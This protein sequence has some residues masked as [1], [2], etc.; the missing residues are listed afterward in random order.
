MHSGTYRHHS[1]HM[2]PHLNAEPRWRQVRLGLG[3]VLL[4]YLAVGAAAVAGSALLWLAFH[5]NQ[6][7]QGLA[8][9]EDGK[10]L[11]TVGGVAALGLGVL[12]GSVLVLAGQWLCLTNAPSR[13]SARELMLIALLCSILGLGITG[14][15]PFV[16]GS[17]TYAAL[18][19]G[20][21]G[22]DHLGLL[23]GGLL[24]HL[25]GLALGL[26]SC[27]TFCLFLRAI[28]SYFGSPE[29]ARHI[30]IHL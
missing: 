23:S 12:I 25:L 8:D 3:L 24:V 4:G 22:F 10:N 21:E 9:G 2:I 14:L 1:S 20:V 18:L 13:H 17:W 19:T 29:G 28:A 11:L 27:L 15:A 5:P 7:P 26:G 30:D 6:V 16:G